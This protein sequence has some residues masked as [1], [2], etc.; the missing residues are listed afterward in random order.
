MLEDIVVQE[1]SIKSYKEKLNAET[2]LP[3][4]AAE[5]IKSQITLNGLIANAIRQIGDGIAWRAFDYDRFTHR[6]LCSHPVKQTILAEGTI[7]ELGHWAAI[8]DSANRKAIF[9]AA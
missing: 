4:R 9:N 1:R 8:N 5:S 7:A 3:D 2:S 6:I